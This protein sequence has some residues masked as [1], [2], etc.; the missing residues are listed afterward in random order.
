MLI[1]LP[2]VADVMLPDGNVLLGESRGVQGPWRLLPSKLYIFSSEAA[3]Y[4]IESRHVF[5]TRSKINHMLAG[6]GPPDIKCV[7]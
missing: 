2:G 6:L 4:S 5:L 7:G 1:R 3:T